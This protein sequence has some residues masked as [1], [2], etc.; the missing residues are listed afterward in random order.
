MSCICWKGP[1]E[2]VNHYGLDASRNGQPDGSTLGICVDCSS[3]ISR[4]PTARERL[5][6]AGKLEW[7]NDFQ[8]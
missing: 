7:Q 8:T 5:Y 6:T 4:T 2:V 1:R 3:V